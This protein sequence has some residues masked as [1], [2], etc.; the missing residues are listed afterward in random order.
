[1][2][3]QTKLNA[4][5]ALLNELGSAVIGF[6]G[7]ADSAFLAAAAHR[8]LGER[9][10][11]VT[12]HSATLPESE[13]LEA[14]VIARQIGIKHVLLPQ[15]E[16]DSEDFARN[17]ADRCY[18]CKKGRFTALASWASLH[19]FRWVLEG[20]N[21][22]DTGDYRPGLRALGELA[23]VRS[24]LL[25]VGFTKAEI[26][27]LSRL[28]GLPTWN[29]PSAAC[30]SSRIAY[31]QRVTAEK[32]AQIERAEAVLKEY[33]SGQVRV[34]HH[35]NLARLEVEPEEI[36]RLAAPPVAKEIAVRLKALGFTFVT[37]DL[38]GYR[39]GSMNQILDLEGKNNG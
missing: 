31:G 18:Y 13:R 3:H 8:V 36:A 5:N 28:W 2:N 23:S 35:G 21:A 33:S 17:D 32:L 9:A 1:M 15:N 27:E 29:K 16:L 20:A 24:P 14:A 22:D 10:V 12:C 37:V 7:G 4:L 38:S 26:R 19:G 34:R 30:L 39:T 25:E 6:S 11:A